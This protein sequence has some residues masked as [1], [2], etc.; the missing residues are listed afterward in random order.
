MMHWPFEVFPGSRGHWRK[1]SGQ[2]HKG[3][4]MSYFICLKCHDL[5]GFFPQIVTGVTVTGVT[6]L[7]D[8]T[9]DIPV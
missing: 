3:S 4:Q 8:N 1:C 6:P 2:R 9:S 7:P 5:L